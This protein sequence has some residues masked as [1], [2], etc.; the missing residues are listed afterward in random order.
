ML[1]L[2]LQKPPLMP[3]HLP[4]HSLPDAQRTSSILFTPTD[5]RRIAGMRIVITITII[6]V[7]RGASPELPA[8]HNPPTKHGFGDDFAAAAATASS[9]APRLLLVQTLAES[10]GK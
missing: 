7:V 8:R 4:F 1:P 3:P 6:G 2:L 5:A 10:K 9:G